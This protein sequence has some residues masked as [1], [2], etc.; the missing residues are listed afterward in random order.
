MCDLNAPFLL[1]KIK[2]NTNPMTTT[3]KHKKTSY[4][5]NPIILLILVQTKTL[6]H[7]E[8]SYPVNP[9]SEKKRQKKMRNSRHIPRPD[10]MQNVSVT[11]RKVT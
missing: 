3:L 9:G 6:K 1:T 4:P 8:V 5:V 10:W 7:K 2:E 11:C